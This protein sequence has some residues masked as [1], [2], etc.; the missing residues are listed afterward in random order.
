MTRQSV[1][2]AGTGPRPARRGRRA[3]QAAGAAAGV[4]RGSPPSHRERRPGAGRRRSCGTP[5]AGS[6]AEERRVSSSGWKQQRVPRAGET[7]RMRPRGGGA[8]GPPRRGG[9]ARWLASAW[10]SGTRR[11]ATRGDEGGRAVAVGTERATRGF[12]GGE[13]VLRRA[14][15]SLRRAAEQPGSARSEP[16]RH[17]RELGGV[18]ARTEVR[19]DGACWCG[20]SRAP[21]VRGRSS[22]EVRWPDA[23]H[24][25]THAARPWPQ[26][27]SAAATQPASTVAPGQAATCSV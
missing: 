25:H 11:R 14:R 4:E 15:G 12:E 6:R 9:T 18:A 27:V 3:E 26:L 17:A 20:G 24:S 23:D 5:D 21:R 10:A 1:R 13:A 16:S 8:G 7:R 19:A 22:C 2:E